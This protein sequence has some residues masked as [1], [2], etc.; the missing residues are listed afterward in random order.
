LRA[1]LRRAPRQPERCR[2]IGELRIGLALEF[3][4]LRVGAHPDLDLWIA[5]V[6]EHAGLVLAAPSG[7]NAP[8]QGG[9]FVERALDTG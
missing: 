7:E 9:L 2:N 6:A 8:N 5:A 4:E 3:A 1:R